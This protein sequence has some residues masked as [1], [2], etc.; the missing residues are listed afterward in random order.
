M[1]DIIKCARQESRGI[2]GLCARRD[3]GDGA[4]KVEGGS[5]GSSGNATTAVTNQLLQHISKMQGWDARLLSAG[6]EAGTAIVR[7]YHHVVL[8]QC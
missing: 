6:N 1:A 5:S 2:C 8:G 4:R 3:I 7:E